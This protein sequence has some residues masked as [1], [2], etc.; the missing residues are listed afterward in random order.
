MSSSSSLDCLELCRLCLEK[1]RVSVPIFENEGDVRQIFLKITA[2]LPVKVS[3]D[4]KLPKKICDDCLYKVELFY[5]FWNTTANAEKQLLQWLGEVG[6]LEDGVPEV[7]VSN[8]MKQ[9]Q[10]SDSRLEGRVVQ[11]GGQN[12][13]DMGMIENMTIITMPVDG[14]QQFASVPM[15]TS[16][17]VTVQA[18]ASS[19]AS[20]ND[21]SQTSVSHLADEVEDDDDDD[22]DDGCDNEGMPVKE[23][24]EE[25][26]SDRVLDQS[27]FVTIPCD[28]AG[29]SGLQQKIADISN[30]S[31]QPTE[32]NDPKTGK[33]SAAVDDPETKDKYEEAEA[34]DSD[35]GPEDIEIKHHLNEEH[36][37]EDVSG[38]GEDY[39][40]ESGIRIA[41]V[42]SMRTD[43]E[44]Q[45]FQS[46]TDEPM[47]SEADD[48]D[49][50]VNVN[51]IR[52]HGPIRNL[53]VK[54][55]SGAFR[56]LYQCNRCDHVF[57]SV[58]Q[59]V[60]H[61]QVEHPQSRKYRLAYRCKSCQKLFKTKIGCENH[62]ASKHKRREFKCKYCDFT[63]FSRNYIKKHEK[64]HAD[65][66]NL[67][68]DECGKGFA[69]KIV[70]ER[71]CI[72]HTGAKPFSCDICKACYAD[73]RSLTLHMTIHAPEGRQKKYTC[74]V[75][76]Y[77][78]FWK[79]AVKTHMKVHTGAK[80][81]CDECGTPVASNYYL[82]IHKRIHSDEKPFSCDVCS[83]GFRQM[84]NL[85]VHQRT[86]TKVKPYKCNVCGKCFSQNVWLKKH[87]PKRERT[88]IPSI[89][90]RKPKP[91]L[92]KDVKQII[93]TN[94]APSV[95]SDVRINILGTI[96]NHQVIIYHPPE[97]SINRAT[98]NSI[99]IVSSDEEDTNTGD[100]R[101]EFHSGDEEVIHRDEGEDQ[102]NEEVIETESPTVNMIAY[103]CD[104]CH[105]NFPDSSSL[106]IHKTERSIARTR[107]ALREPIAIHT[108]KM[109]RARFTSKPNYI[110]HIN[111]CGLVD[112]NAL[113]ESCKQIRKPRIIYPKK[114]KKTNET[115]GQRETSEKIHFEGENQIAPCT[116][117]NK[118]FKKDKYL[119]VHMIAAHGELLVCQICG[120]KFNSSNKLRKH[121]TS[122]HDELNEPCTTCG[123]VF[124]S[125]QSLKVHMAAHKRDT[126]LLP[127]NQCDRSFRHESYL[128]KHIQSFHVENKG[129]KTYHCEECGYE[130]VYKA[131]FREHMAKHTGEDQVTCDICSKKMRKG[132]MKLHMRIHSGERPEICEYCGKGFAA[133]KYLKK[134]I[135]VHTGEKPHTCHVCGCELSDPSPPL[136][137]LQAP[138][139]LED[140]QQLEPAPPTDQEFHELKSLPPITTILPVIKDPSDYECPY[141]S[142]RFKTKILYDGHLVSHSDA[143]P[144]QC[145][146]CK[147]CFKRSN[148][149]AVHRRIHSRDKSHVCDVCGRG[150]VQAS[151]L[152][153]HQRRHYEKYSRFCNVCGKGFFT[154]AELHGHMN[155]KHGAQEHVCNICSKQMPNAH[156]L[157]RHMK[158]HEPGYQPI[159]HHCEIC[160]KTFAFKNSLVAHVKAHNGDNKHECHICHKQVSSRSSLQDHLRLH[161]SE[162][163]LVCD[164][165]G[166]AFH[167]KTTLVVHRRIHTGEKPYSC[168]ICGKA[169]NQHSTLVIHKRYHTGHRPYECEKCEKSFVSRALLNAHS[170]VHKRFTLSPKELGL[171]DDNFNNGQMMLVMDKSIDRSIDECLDSQGLENCFD[172]HSLDSESLGD[173]L[174]KCPDP[175]HCR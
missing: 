61:M 79:N 63:T 73:K 11:V 148:T 17:T 38:D 21:Q 158:S 126:K 14:E 52:D 87:K 42:A 91:K 48:D 109:C 49:D 39:F 168:D 97:N 137:I 27:S 50:E 100:F 122:I 34:V 169:F 124:Y 127:C 151:Q 147:K 53:L 119:K 22:D 36:S 84:K 153:T 30:M 163:E 4:D 162:K 72:S 19:S 161:T 85:V 80:V 117:C 101:L 70:L 128:Q 23:E 146:Y 77:S 55:E 78:S 123:K 92:S 159:K 112:M 41:S 67:R 116:Q 141:C 7:L 82:K 105:E 86:H 108:C 96:N 9:E 65:D 167:K 93:N 132:Y 75:C 56:N 68:C 47:K 145:E 13:V 139:L 28:E 120:E 115:D 2:C 66:F 35:G 175:G 83:K 16:G 88:R 144:Y 149:L 143:R 131:C 62:I 26:Q 5:Q 154:N 51:D 33:S 74:D 32:V 69:S 166:K 118:V 90:Q 71:H 134:H 110:R 25:D 130:S 142:K 165:C 37:I 20:A 46:E 99:V 54:L 121:I 104:S 15:D 31:L 156:T 174:R 40:D 171:D 95:N 81:I 164:V 60:K 113:P 43:C 8:V 138:D 173:F 157:K 76:D 129:R 57:P 103:E 102:L 1:E 3:R 150:F 125:R 160:G 89:L 45:Q 170:K 136:P 44:D 18:V 107:A 10:A 58:R 64:N 140:H 135:V 172:S 152:K 106:I 6:G 29:P 24:N 59:C 98:D 12:S 114:E 133:R 111:N 155:I 94:A